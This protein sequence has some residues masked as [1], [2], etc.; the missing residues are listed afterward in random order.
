MQTKAKLR[1]EEGVYVIEGTKLFMEAPVAL[2]RE[3]YVSVDFYRRVNDLEKL[4]TLPH[5]IV[6]ADVFARMSDTQSPQGILCVMAE[7]KYNISDI[8]GLPPA[9]APL[10][11][12]CE[13]IN[14]PGNMGTI[15]R[16]AE[17]AGASAVI[18]SAGCVDIHNPKSVRA[19]MGSI[20]R[21]PCVHAVDWTALIQNLK[22]KGF[23]L[24]AASPDGSQAYDEADFCE[25]TA[26]IIGSESHGLPDDTKAA[27]TNISIPMLGAVESLNVAT[28]AAILL[29]EAAR[30]RRGIHNS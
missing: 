21:M 30:Q 15:I 11:L 17:A 18:V 7:E 13:G 3:V 22:N 28:A 23:K 26:F 24:Y 19:T 4:S 1:A 14:D 16:S 9:P 25:R 20:F 5:E 8:L 10:L 27:L 2:I 6:S 12:L 29:H